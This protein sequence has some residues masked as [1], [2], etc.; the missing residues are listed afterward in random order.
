MPAPVDYVACAI[1][2]AASAALVG[3]ASVQLTPTWKERLQLY[4]GL[5][6]NSGSK[7]TP[8]MNAICGPLTEWY[9]HNGISSRELAEGFGKPIEEITTDATPEALVMDMAE[10][11]GRGII[12]S[13]EGTI[14]SIMAG[15]TYG[16]AGS[17]TNIDIALHG[18][19]DGT[20]RCRRKGENADLRISHANLSI[21]VGL[22]PNMLELFARNKYL[23]ERGLPQ[24]FLFFIPE[25]MGRCVISE[26]PPTDMAR[27]DAWAEKIT[28]LAA[29]FRDEPLTLKLDMNARILFDRYRQV[30]EDRRNVEWCDSQALEAW[31][32]KAVGMT[33]RLA[34]ILTLLKDPTART[35]EQHE[36][37]CAQQMMEE[38]FIPHMHYA[39]CGEQR[40]SPAAE[41]VL[42]AMPST[43]TR[44][45]LCAP[46]AA[47]WDKLRKKEPF[48]V[49]DGNTLFEKALAELA[50]AHLIRPAAIETAATGRPSKGAWEVHPKILAN[51]P[52]LQPIRTGDEL[53]RHFPQYLAGPKSTAEAIE[54]M[55][56]E[57]HA[58]EGLPF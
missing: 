31:A 37:R 48:K 17:A 53:N 1:L 47:L 38:Y 56:Q 3:R 15:T 27:L 4:L 40:L 7:K 30:M 28:L 23:N 11:D 14:L 43:M 19:N 16:K 32:S 46:Q 33:A 34:G 18:W 54:A 21:M 49:R 36:F 10:H 5:V 58:D 35:I 52:A 12:L 25:P 50:A 8:V 24:R 22:Q 9:D 57:N 39:F 6:G 13:D 41:A 26:L 29:S 2:G 42:K 55:Q 44:S 20:V 45:C 51:V